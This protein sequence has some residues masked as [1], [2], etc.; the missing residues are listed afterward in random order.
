[1]KIYILL[2]LLPV[3]TSCVLSQNVSDQI[4]IDSNRTFNISDEDS[5]V[6]TTYHGPKEKIRADLVIEGIKVNDAQTIKFSSGRIKGDTVEIFLY[7]TS[8]G[9]HHEYKIQ[10]FESRFNIT[11]HYSTS[12]DPHIR[13]IS[14][15]KSSLVLSSNKFAKGEVVRGYTEYYGK[16]VKGCRNEDYKIVGNFAVL[17]E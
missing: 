6:R 8:P 4:K 17:L 14:T 13:Q 2:F 5:I 11:Y 7:H 10:I 12:G 1:M 16:C 9:F 3:A 15:I